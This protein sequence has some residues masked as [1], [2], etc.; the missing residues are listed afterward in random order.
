M[1]DLRK[2]GIVVAVAGAICALVLF[3][4][5][6]LDVVGS[7]FYDRQVSYWT[8][9]R[10][11]VIFYVGAIGMLAFAGFRIAQGKGFGEIML[12]LLSWSGILLA[13][14]ATYETFGVAWMLRTFEI[15]GFRGY[16]MFDPTYVTLGAVGLL[17][18]LLG[19]LMRRA[20]DMARELEEFL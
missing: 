12:R 7:A 19:R 16:G 10:V 9:R 5:V 8:V 17:L 20:V 18:W 15:G 14:G 13:V 11:A 4:I 2:E 1:A 6:V 3:L